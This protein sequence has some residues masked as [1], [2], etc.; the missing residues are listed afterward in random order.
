MT[1]TAEY[2]IDWEICCVVKL[3]QLCST[4]NA[5]NRHWLM[6]LPKTGNVARVKLTK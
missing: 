1:I 5:W 3:V 6:F 2:A 4:W